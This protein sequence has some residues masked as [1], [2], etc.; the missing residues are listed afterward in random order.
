MY[1][2]HQPSAL[3]SETQSEP[4]P[5]H[6]QTEDTKQ[7]LSFFFNQL[8]KRWLS[9]ITS[10]LSLRLSALTKPDAHHDAI[11]VGLRPVPAR[12]T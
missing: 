9:I 7:S 4:L 11:L 8:L 1:K 12:V 5:L 6:V 10:K 3:F 2:L